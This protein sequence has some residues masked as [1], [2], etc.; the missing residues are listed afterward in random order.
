MTVSPSGPGGAASEFA[1]FLAD[2]WSGWLD[3]YPEIATVCG[4][5]GRNDRWTDDSPDGI[6][7]R[8]KHLEASASRIGR[9]ESETL[10]PG[11]R[12]SFALYRDLVATALEGQRFGNDPLPFRFGFPHNLWIPINQMDG[13][14]ITAADMMEL[15]PRVTVRDFDDRLARLERL[16]AAIEQNLALLREGLARGFSPPRIAV[17]G[18]PDQMAKLVPADPNESAILRPFHEFPAAVGES[19]RRRIIAEA[20]RRFVDL[21]VPALDRLREYYAGA[22]LAGSRDEVGASA[23]PEGRALYEYLVRWETTTNLTPQQIHELGLAEVGR[24]RTRMETV[25]K[26]AGFDG[27]L[28]EFAEFLRTEPRFFWPNAAAL[29]DGY[30]AVAKRIDPT[31]GR[32]F[33]RLPRLPYG[34]LPVPGYRE[35]SSPSAYYVPGAPA[36][37]RPGYF[38]ANSYRVEVRPRWEMEALTLHEAVPGHHL[39]LAI[40]GE[41]EGV[42]EFRQ[43]SGATAFIEGWGLYAESLGDELG[44]YEDPYSRMGQLNYDMWRSIRLVVDTGM[45]ALGWSRD[46]AIAFFRENTGKSDVDIAIEVDRYIVWPGQALAYKVGQ[47]KFRELRSLAERELGERF[48]VRAFHDLVLEQ[49]ALPLGDVESRVRAWIDE[50]RAG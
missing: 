26:E 24:I 14:Q 3:Q 50:R 17:R 16:P 44:C 31:L 33:G 40:A 15:A 10:P 38:F 25:R 47:L 8:R 20:R 42:P 41:L 1:R 49:G 28:A 5:P 34:V 6:A 2:D 12:L 27:T 22:Y 13:I 45:H 48:D 23:L 32:L 36:T 35:A 43:F 4:Y 11:D 30:R 39:Q 19:D 29:V 7:A 37:G 18:V 21:I 9:F 46:R